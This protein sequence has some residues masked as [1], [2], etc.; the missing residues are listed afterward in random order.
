MVRTR[1]RSQFNSVPRRFSRSVLSTDPPRLRFCAGS[2]H[3]GGIIGI[4]SLPAV[5]NLPAG[6]VARGSISWFARVLAPS[7]IACPGASAA[8]FF[9][10]T[11]PACVYVQA[12]AILEAFSA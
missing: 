11:R 12:Q 1:A 7:L 9:P 10:L 5:S 3:F 4:K 6:P 8:T 2:G